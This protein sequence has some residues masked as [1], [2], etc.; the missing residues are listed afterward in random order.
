MKV[1]RTLHNFG[2]CPHHIQSVQALEPADYTA[3]VSFF[4]WLIEHEHH[5]GQ[6]LLTDEA[7]S[8]KDGIMNK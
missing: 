2:M 1:W 3:H 8:T 6:I 7:T 5:G 4:R